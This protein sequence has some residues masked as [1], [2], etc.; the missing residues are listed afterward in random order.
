MVMTTHVGALRHAV[1]WFA[2]IGIE[3]RELVGG[4]VT[5]EMPVVGH[6]GE[7]NRRCSPRKGHGAARGRWAFLR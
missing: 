6:A 7:L 3:E 1:R 4:V 2:E 5:R